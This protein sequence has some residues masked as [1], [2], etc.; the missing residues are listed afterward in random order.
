MR[1]LWLWLAALAPA[2]LG[3]SLALLL[4]SGRLPNPLLSLQADLGTILLLAGLLFSG[5]VVVGMVALRVHTQRRLSQA[6]SEE[7]EQAAEAHR[8]FV[9]RLDHELK[10]PL[11]AMRIGLANLAGT[12][13]RPEQREMLASVETQAERLGRLVTDLRKLVELEARPLEREP[14]D[15]GELLGEAVELARQ[16]AAAGERQIS[17]SVPRAPW[18][19]PPVSG[20]RDLLFLAIY[21]LL[22]NALKF[23]RDG[24]RLEVRAIE[25]GSTVVVEVADTG[26]GVPE[27]ELPHIFEELYRGQQARGVDGSGLGL[28]LVKAVVEQHGGHAAARS[29]P[30]KGSVFTLRLPVSS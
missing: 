5:V 18:P 26:S 13:P 1:R 16:R 10:N 20:D 15:V 19:L 2:V 23:T 17:L 27:E 11:T 4:Q 25:D 24:D 21:N 9:R 7:R 12:S 28:A 30:G 14:V 8:R 22:D 29:R 6:V 3:L